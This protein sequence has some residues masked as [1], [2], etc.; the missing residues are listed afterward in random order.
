MTENTIF[1]KA[2][3]VSELLGISLAYAYKIINTLNKELSDKGYLVI[4]GRTSR[5][6]FYERVYGKAC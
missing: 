5:Q 1:I 6:Y 2:K 4:S 3:E